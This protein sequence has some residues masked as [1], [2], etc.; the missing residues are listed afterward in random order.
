MMFDIVFLTLGRDFEAL[1]PISGPKQITDQPY[2]HPDSH[3][4][5]HHL[6]MRVHEMIEVIGTLTQKISLTFWNRQIS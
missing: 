6:G 5:L 3:H 2:T 1:W 4:K